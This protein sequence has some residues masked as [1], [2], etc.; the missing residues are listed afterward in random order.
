[1]YLFILIGAAAI[2][3]CCLAASFG[4]AAVDRRFVQRL[5]AAV[6]CSLGVVFVV[7]LVCIFRRVPVPYGVAVSPFAIPLL[8]MVQL[9]L[10]SLRF[11]RSEGR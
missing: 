2:Y 10:Y 7:W 11:W 1:V 8:V 4:L 9:L 6:V 5:I 3:I